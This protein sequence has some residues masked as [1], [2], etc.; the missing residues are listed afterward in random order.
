MKKDSKTPHLGIIVTLGV[1]IAAIWML[2]IYDTIQEEHEKRYNVT[3]R[4]GAVSYGTHSSATVPMVSAPTR[5]T[6]APMISGSAVRSYAHYGHAVYTVHHTPY[7][8][9]T[10]SS[11]TV[12][13]IG[14]GGGN[15]GG[16]SSYSGGQGSSS[17]GISYSGGGSGL[18][19]SMPVLAVNSSMMAAPVA[20]AESS[21]PRA[22][23][24]RRTPAT[25][26][27]EE[28]EWKQDE[29]GG[30]FIWDEGEWVALQ[31]GDTRIE[32]GVTYIWNGSGWDIVKDQTDPNLTA[33]V[34]AT[35]WLLMILLTCVYALGKNY[36]S[37][38][39]FEKI[40]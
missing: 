31:V 30:W 34:G 19:M 37:Y 39:K 7:T 23:G 6:A 26:G 38:S 36:V 18:S 3:V 10:T 32:G 8:V 33:P 28:G 5:H 9:H 17:R 12:H 4:P 11:A 29:Y 15:G 22:I 24:P 35:P 25:P 16:T 27:T 21:R 40:S 20:A 13:T 14:S 1:L 2:A